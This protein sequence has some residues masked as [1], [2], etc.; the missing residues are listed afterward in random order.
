MAVGVSPPIIPDHEMLRVIGRGAYGEIWLARSLT[1]ALRAVKIVYRSTFENERAFHREFSGMSHFEPFSR[2]Q[3]GFVDILHVGRSAEFFYY[4]MELAD[5]CVSGQQID[6]VKYEPRTLKTELQMRGSLPVTECIEIGLRLTEALGALHA[7]GL[8][9]RDIKPANIIFVSATLKLAD[10]GL[11]AATGQLSFVGTEGYVPPEGPGAPQGDI[12]SLGKVLYEIC[13]GK[14]RLD[15]PSLNTDL[16]TRSDKALLMQLNE[17]LLKACANNP[18]A[19]YETAAEMHADLK[20]VQCGVPV[21]Q[22]RKLP[23]I[24]LA[25]IFLC[26]AAGI[27]SMQLFKQQP[28]NVL[29]TQG[30]VKITSQPSGAMVVIGDRVSRTPAVFQNIE[31]GKY[32]V[33]VMLGGFEPVET[34]VEITRNEPLDLGSISLTRSKG[35]L[36]LTSEPSGAD[37]ELRD[38]IQHQ[39]VR[40]GKTPATVRDLP[41]G[42]YEVTV[43]NHD[44]KLQDTVEIERNELAVKAFEFANGTL[45]VSS[46]PAGAEISVDG[47]LAGQ[48]PLRLEL[49]SGSHEI[50][51]ALSDWP[52][53]H[54]SVTIANHRVMEVSFDFG[55]GSV[56]ITSAP[57]GATVT[58]GGAELGQTPLLLEE[59]KP[60]ELEYELHLTGYK[61]AVVRGSV[62]PHKQAFLAARLER[63]LSPEPGKA[64]ENSLGM[65][66]VPVGNLR[67]C[68][69]ET[70]VEDFT[71]FCQETGARFEKPDFAQTDAHPAVKVNWYDAQAFCKWLTEKERA[72]N[73]LEENQRYRLPTDLEWSIAAGLPNEAGNTPE[74]RD[75][76]IKD[77]FPWGKQ[78]PPPSGAG[79]YA[80]QSTKRPRGKIIEN[81]N[82]GFAQTAPVG[83]FSPNPNGLYDMGGNVWEWC[84]EGY[85]GGATAKD[86]GVLRGGSWANSSRGELQSSYRNVVDRSERDVIYGFR[87]VLVSDD[88]TR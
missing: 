88:P 19:R 69:W 38:S 28:R 48:T 41:T 64:W 43:R 46:D 86:W 77:V 82:D 49:P 17:V 42:R 55:Y 14:D 35:A 58:N 65:K 44:W 74:E 51:A 24:A 66:F 1:G 68:A 18:A 75:G 39:I 70:R 7:Q 67:V 59:I 29:H 31:E 11:V 76:K 34:S 62:Q 71:A 15:F 57:G 9:H 22:P 80:D 30:E 8:A 83:S 73:L 50:A 2:E 27:A 56:K 16:T 78:W 85:N 60:G 79:N 26:A 32:P 4:I 52:R 33:R 72:E 54:R 81:F 21:R 23:K 20:R 25:L 47:K 36:Q 40:T 6:P 63:K 13:T 61:P 84:E 12:F 3:S 45:A 10:I 87:C 37:F 5:D 53:E